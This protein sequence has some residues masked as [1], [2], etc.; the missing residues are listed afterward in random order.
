MS[1]PSLSNQA[2]NPDQSVVASQQ[3]QPLTPQNVQGSAMLDAHVEAG[4]TQPEGEPVNNAIATNFSDTTGAGD[5]KTAG[6]AGEMGAFSTDDPSAEKG[7]VNLHNNPDVPADRQDSL[8]GTLPD[9]DSTKM[10]IDPAT[11]LPD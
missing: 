3:S 9:T 4:G 10:P 8:Q 11:N 5:P 1:D 2:T 6:V 7:S